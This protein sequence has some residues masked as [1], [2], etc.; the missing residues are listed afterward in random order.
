MAF[1][2]VPLIVHLAFVWML[3]KHLEIEFSKYSGIKYVLFRFC[4]VLNKH[5]IL[6]VITH[7]GI[8]DFN[9][10]STYHV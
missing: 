1:V 6:H 4:F 3:H 7:S 9:V 10:G 2:G 8:C 5:V